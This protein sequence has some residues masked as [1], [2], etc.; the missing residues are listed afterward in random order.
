MNTIEKINRAKYQT[1]KEILEKAYEFYNIMEIESV[2]E[3]YNHLETYIR[4]E[5]LFE[6]DYTKRN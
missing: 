1:A 2:N 4:K 3:F 5:H 6:S